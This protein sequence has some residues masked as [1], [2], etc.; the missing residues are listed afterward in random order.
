MVSLAVDTWKTSL[1]NHRFPTLFPTQP[2]NVNLI[3]E[4]V[5]VLFQI[6]REYIEIKP[7]TDEIHCQI[8][9]PEKLINQLIFGKIRLQDAINYDEIQF[10]GSY[11]NILLLEAIFWLNR[12]EA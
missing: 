10:T 4:N 2:L 6:S 7:P 11:R 1:E 3:T 9:A 5:D 8:Q 12:K